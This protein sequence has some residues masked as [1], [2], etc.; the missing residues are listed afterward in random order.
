[1]TPAEE[2]LSV[3]LVDDQPLVRA[4]LRTLLELPDGHQPIRIE[5]EADNGRAAMARIRERR[6]EVVIM[7]I[8]MPVM[9]GIAALKAI[10][11]DHALAELPVL[12]LTTFDTDEF[13][14]DSLAAGASGFLVKDCEP[15]ELRGGV[16]SVARGDA[17]LSS[18]VTT[19]VIA[20]ATSA[21]HDESLA[22]QLADQLTGRELEVLSA[23]ARGLS[24][25]EI[26]DALF[27]SPATTRTYVSRLLAKLGCRDRVAL[28]IMAYESGLAPAS[29]DGRGD[30][31][32]LRDG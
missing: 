18:A 21:S 30:T 8:R 15:D 1:M 16:R 12:M 6:P 13:L 11:S 2:P 24:N 31:D 32:R 7:D 10:R 9:D 4:G 19:R 22:R 29:R 5:A 27:L 3:V 23:V 14:F 20:R 25:D 28:V 26:A 17:L